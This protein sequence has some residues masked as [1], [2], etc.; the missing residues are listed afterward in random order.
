[1]KDKIIF[2][3]DSFTWGEGLELFIDSK[4][5]INQRELHSEWPELELLQDEESVLFREKNRYPTLVADELNIKPIVYPDNG[6]DFSQHLKLIDCIE[7]TS[8]VKHIFVQ[9]SQINR[10]F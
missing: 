8:D 10:N 5:W 2:A 6:G 7:D 9:L 4:K 1:M 3:G